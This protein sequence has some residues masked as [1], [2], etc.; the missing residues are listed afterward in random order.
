VRALW[1]LS[2][3]D[4]ASL[5]SEVFAQAGLPVDEARAGVNDLV[6]RG[7]VSLRASEPAEVEEA[8]NGRAR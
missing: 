4:G 5:L 6:R 3:I 1:L 8:W 2:Y 7:I